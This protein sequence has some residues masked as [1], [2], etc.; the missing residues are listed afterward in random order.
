MN[1]KEYLEGDYSGLKA[2]VIKDL[3][4]YDN[5]EDAKSYLNDVT[6]Y[7]CISG[8]VSKLIYY[9]DTNSFYDEN[10][11]EI[12]ELLEEMR[13][14][15]GYESRLKFISSLNGADNISSMTEEKNLLAW[16]AYEEES[17]RVLEELEELEEESQE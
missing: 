4:D 17:N 15:L 10:E 1:Y 9:S 13:D 6:Q 12:E 2:E 5:L 11:N 16:F 7:G 14:N 8:A 3:K